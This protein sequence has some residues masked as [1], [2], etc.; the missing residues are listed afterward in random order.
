MEV[1]VGI[2]VIPVEG[3]DQR[4]EALR[5]VAIAQVLADDGAVLTFHQGIVV[6]PSRPAFA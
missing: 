1:D 3:V 6:M 2:E 5:D 4:G